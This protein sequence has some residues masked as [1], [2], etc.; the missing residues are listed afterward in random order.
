ML[1]LVAQKCIDSTGKRSTGQLAQ[2]I[3]SNDA[4]TGSTTPR[5]RFSSRP[6]SHRVSGEIFEK[7]PK[8]ILVLV[9][10]RVSR[11]YS[12]RECNPTE[13]WRDCKKRIWHCELAGGRVAETNSQ[14]I[15]LGRRSYCVPA[16]IDG[17]DGYCK[18]VAAV[19]EYGSGQDLLRRGGQ[20]A[21][22]Y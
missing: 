21:A 7:S 19:G 18:I 13:D 16:A 15:P 1:L 6:G 22:A 12:G 5:P 8:R 17:I 4:A 14:L 10:L 3:A 11:G 20:S 2:R 9:H